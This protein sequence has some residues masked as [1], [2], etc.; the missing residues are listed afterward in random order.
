MAQVGSRWD[1]SNSWAML[2]NDRYSPSRWA[3]LLPVLTKVINIIG[4][5]N[6]EPS[7]LT[8]LSLRCCSYGHAYEA[9]T[10]TPEIVNASKGAQTV[11]HHPQQRLEYLFSKPKS[12]SSRHYRRYGSFLNKDSEQL[13]ALMLQNLH[14]EILKPV[15]EQPRIHSLVNDSKRFGKLEQAQTGSS[16]YLPG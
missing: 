2:C 3:R 10:L 1:S 9:P 12:P 7:N 4:S 16:T 15:V 14:L 13:Q 6:R 5:R 11:A 8:N